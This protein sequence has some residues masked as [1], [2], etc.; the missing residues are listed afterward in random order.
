MR[1]GVAEPCRVATMLVI[2]VGVGMRLAMG[3]M[4]DWAATVMR[5][6]EVAATSWKRASSQS[7]AAPMPRWE[8]VWLERVCR[9]PKVVR[10]LT[11]A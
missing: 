2:G 1:S 5:P 8:S 6:S 7:R 11:V 4:N 10:P 3:W 9:V